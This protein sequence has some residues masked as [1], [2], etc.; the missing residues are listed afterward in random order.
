MQRT[1]AEIGRARDRAMLRRLRKKMTAASRVKTVLPIASEGY[2]I[3]PGPRSAHWLKAAQVGAPRCCQAG[4]SM[5]VRL[6]AVKP[7][8]PRKAAMKIQP[9]RRVYILEEAE[10]F[11][12]P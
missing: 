6:R 8:P 10:C 7:L 3:R 12:L 2:K 9:R 11:A 5:S 4:I 1:A